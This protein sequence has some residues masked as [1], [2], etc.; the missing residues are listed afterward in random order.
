MRESQGQRQSQSSVMRRAAFGILA[1]E[2]KA[3]LI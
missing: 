1:P 3:E 2:A